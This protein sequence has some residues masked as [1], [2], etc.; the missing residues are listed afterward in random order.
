MRVLDYEPRQVTERGRSA[1]RQRIAK[2]L[3]VALL[4][5]I[6]A[7]L[8]YVLGVIVWFICCWRFPPLR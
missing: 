8:L 6:W 4:I 2:R 5:I 7:P 1:T 3:M